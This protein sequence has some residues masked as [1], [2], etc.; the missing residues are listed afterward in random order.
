MGSEMCIRDRALSVYFTQFA[1]YSAYGAIGTV[2]ALL[3]ALWIF[4]IVL[5][6]GLEV[7][8]E[9]ER[10]RQLEAGLPAEARVQLPPKDVA[11][12][13]KRAEKQTT[14]EERGY[15]LRAVHEGR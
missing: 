1:G 12:V 4:N 8:A 11:G 2:M 13:E 9:V 10:A 5:L 7:D 14:V 3:F 6:L 15:E